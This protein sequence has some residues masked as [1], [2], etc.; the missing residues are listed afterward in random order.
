MCSA[1]TISANYF[2]LGQPYTP[3]QGALNCNSGGALAIQRPGNPYDGVF[4][5]LRGCD[6]RCGVP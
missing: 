3:V 5:T 6:G 1:M 2:T 4:N